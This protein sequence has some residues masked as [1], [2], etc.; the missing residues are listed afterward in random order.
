VNAQDINK[1][2]FTPD[3]P[4]PDADLSPDELFFFS[5]LPQALSTEAEMMTIY[6]QDSLDGKRKC[7]QRIHVTGGTN[8]IL[9]NSLRRYRPFTPSFIGRAEDQAYILS[10]LTKQ[11]T[12]LAYV[13]KDGLIMRHDKEAFV[14]EAIHSAHVGKLIGDY[15]RIILFSAYAKALTDDVPKLKEAIDPFTGCF[16]SL[17]PATVVYL[18]FGFK[19]ASFFEIGQEE[20]GIE[21][22]KNGAKRITKALDFVNGEN[23]MLR[24]I[25][26]NQR[27]GWNIYYDTL[28]AVENGLNHGDDFALGLRKK[29]KNIIEQCSIRV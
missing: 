28:S 25:Y 22:I 15:V 21:F 10:V 27:L 2:L 26:E 3:I 20:Q 5:R 11:G 1:S 24:H 29:A 23:S 6:N 16:V 17:I 12:K 9:V 7:I 19:A 18:R 4:F 14:Q 8:G 13:H